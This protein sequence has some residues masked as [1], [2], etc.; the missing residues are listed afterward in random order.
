MRVPESAVP[1]RGF[2]VLRVRF[3]AGRGLVIRGRQRH[4][5]RQPRGPYRARTCFWASTLD[6][7]LHPLWSGR[8]GTEPPIPEMTLRKDQSDEGEAMK[9]L[10]WF[11]CDCFFGSPWAIT[12]LQATYKNSQCPRC[13]EPISHDVTPGDECPNCGHV[14]WLNESPTPERTAGSIRALQ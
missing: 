10:W 8:V 1:S 3:P 4:Q 14:L 6:G 9:R 7:H 12:E 2:S 5:P 13:R 11:I